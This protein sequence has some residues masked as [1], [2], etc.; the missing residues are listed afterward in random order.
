MRSD[1]DKRTDSE[2]EIDE[3]LSRFETPVDD[4]SA[5]IDAYLGDTDSAKVTAA[6]TFYN[7]NYDETKATP[8]VSSSSDGKVSENTVSAVENAAAAASADGASQTAAPG[9]INKKNI[10]IKKS[11]MKKKRKKKDKAKTSDK[12][13]ALSAVADKVESKVENTEEKIKSVDKKALAEKLFCKDNPDYDPAKPAEYLVGKKLVKN[14]RYVVSVKKII[15]DIVALGLACVLLFVLY[16]L[17]CITLAEKID[18]DDIY[19]AIAT[20]SEVYDDEGT[21][22]DSI[23]YTENRK[24]VS[25][26]EMP[27]NLINAFIAL[28]D[29]TFWKHHGFNWTRMF[30][31]VLSSITGGGEISGTSTITQQL[32]RN[33]YLSDIK[34]Q[35]SIRRKIL[36]MYYASRLEAHLSKEEII[37][38]Y[39]NTIYLGFN[40]YGVDAAAHTYFSKDVEDLSLVECASL[41]AL[42][43]APHNYALLQYADSTTQASSDA[44]I[45]A[46][47]PDTV[48]TNDISADRRDLALE[49]MLEQG[50]IDQSE[51]DSAVDTP[52]TEFINP[53]IQSGNGNYSYFYDYLVETVID[54]LM[55]EYNMEYDDAERAVYTKGL[56][57]YSTLDSTAQNVIVEEFQDNSNFPTVSAIYNQDA[58]GNILNND[59]VIA[60]YNYDNDFDEDGNFTLSS[61]DVTVNSDGSITIKAGQKLNIYETTVDDTTDYSIEFRTYYTID[62]DQL[63]TMQGGYV[64]IPAEYKTMDDN[65]NVNVSAD[66]FTDYDGYMEINGDEVVIKKTAYSLA[67]KV[68]QP[69]AA[70]TIVGVG[71]GEIK[72][73][74]GGRTFNGQKLLN[75][76]T[77]ARQP[78]SSIKPLAVYGAALQK[79]YELQKDGK[80][81]NY[82]DYGIDK[83]GDDGYGDYI[84]TSSVVVDEKTHID[85]EDWPK[86]SNNSFTGKQTFMT[87]IQQSINTCAVK[88]QLQV[89]NE[90]SM[91]QL[92]K[93]GITTA[94]DDDDE[95]VNDMNPAALALGAM[96]NGVQPLEMALAYAA[97]PGEGKV[98][99]PVCYTK[100]LDRN[101]EVLLESESEQSEALDSGVAWVMQ[102]VLKSVVSKGIGSPAAISG[103][104][105]G[106]KTGTTNDQYDIW[107]DGFTPTYAA[108]LWI[109]TDN[110][111]EMSTM[112]GP[113]AAL[114]GKIMGQIPKA[115]EGSYPEKPSDV[116]KKG[117]YYYTSGT[118]KGL[119]NYKSK[120]KSSKS[121]TESS[122]EAAKKLAEQ[123]EELKKAKELA[124]KKSSS[125]NN[126][127]G[128]S[129]SGGSSGSSESGGSSGGGSSGGSSGGSESGGSSGGS[130]SG[131]SESGNGES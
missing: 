65:G 55:E 64:N 75:R 53:T 43:Q 50:L 82:V 52:V 13:N 62:D 121:S 63:Y 7:F 67:S 111:V 48:I 12:E 73:M 37:E 100:V 2:R 17:G 89:G 35:R 120:S 129:E 11:D 44:K 87:A 9:S 86:N 60:L 125:A 92:K 128:S 40:C 122:E 81:W 57:I 70:M 18:P 110:N 93:F 46:T 6:K 79:S 94:V 22:I 16:G 107:F 104:S 80:K 69:Q 27:E 96:T 45:V 91:N 32:A 83:Q 30:G 119:S 105:V 109:G 95:E 29:K 25:Y 108:S 101:G 88:I 74:V 117:N 20:S 34:S 21:Q 76:A 97:F 68:I 130:E 49:L 71:T 51:Y 113:A 59:D 47:D 126:S 114:W 4:L 54:D 131:G 90:F 28:E 85:G 115:S 23:Y 24:V 78:G 99:T 10:K 103:T 112:S 8:S 26:E 127:S 102:E 3:F 61:D 116:V 5:D 15:R 31:A 38:A 14:K 39:L 41:A 118:E 98:N 56:K 42:P 36:E 19:S 72:A 66:F 1:R 77:N 58:D 123:E 33:V 124:K 106:G 84:T